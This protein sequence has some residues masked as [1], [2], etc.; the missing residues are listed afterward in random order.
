MY[1][2][3]IYSLPAAK[4]ALYK[5]RDSGLPINRVFVVVQDTDR[6]HQMGGAEITERVGDK[7]DEYPVVAALS[8]MVG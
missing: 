6:N 3:R 1:C 5:L 7:A 2:K 4:R 8:G